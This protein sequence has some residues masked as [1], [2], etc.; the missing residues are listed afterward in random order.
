MTVTLTKPGDEVTLTVK[1]VARI[2]STAKAGTFRYQIDGTMPSG[3]EERV[4]LN[5]PVVDREIEHKNYGADATALIGDTYR[6]YRVEAPNNT[7]A[8]GYLNID[9]ATKGDAKPESKR[10]TGP[11]TDTRTAGQREFDA[12]VPPEG[13]PDAPASLTTAQV[14]QQRLDANVEVYFA[15]ARKVAA[16]QAELSAAHEAPFDCASINSMTFSIWNNSR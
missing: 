11:N 15:L 10:L 7:P 14:A 16:F 12:A 4:Y 2:E 8:A 5:T 1:A 3:K 13:A 9:I 6:F